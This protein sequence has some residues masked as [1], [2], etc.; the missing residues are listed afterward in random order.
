[1]VEYT[2]GGYEQGVTLEGGFKTSV[3]DGIKV[4]EIVGIIPEAFSF[5][6]GFLADIVEF[7]VFGRFDNIRDIFLWIES[8][9]DFKDF[10][11]VLSA[12]R[13]LCVRL[14]GDS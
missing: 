9:T 14:P 10:Q 2:G 5:R 3:E 7:D 11:L 1:M 8:L 4:I 12:S 13:L 6:I